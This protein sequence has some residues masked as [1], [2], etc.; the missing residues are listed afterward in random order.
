[1]PNTPVDSSTGA[2]HEQFVTTHW[3]VVMAAAHGENLQAGAALEKLCETYW[4]PLY[5]FVRRLGHS[6][7]DAEDVVQGFFA[8]CVKKNYLHS[9]DQA[10][11]RFR[12]FL[13][14]ALKRYLAKE[15]EKSHAR[16]RG[17]GQT[18]IA[19]DGLAAERR[20]ALEPAEQLSADKLYE[21]RWALTLLEQVLSRLREEQAV[22]GR[23]EA[24][25][26]MKEFLQSGGRGTPYSELAS[27]LGGS[28]GSVKVAIHR[29]RR[30]YRELLDEEIA[31]TVATAEEVAEE[32][33][34]LRK[35]LSG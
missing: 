6:S 21:R 15:H 22:T 17:G 12:S 28:E 25:E 5:A 1:M 7:H 18:M 2:R 27:R 4:Y 23:L 20:Y 10:K 9:V 14:L 3:S 11:G 26:Q 8:Q 24:F 19:L 35:A 13:L 34:H 16:K 29:L 31:H 32:R 30:R 33:R